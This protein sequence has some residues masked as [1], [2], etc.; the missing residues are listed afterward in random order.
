LC[1]LT[2]V[3]DAI[4]SD[5]DTLFTAEFW[6]ELHRLIGTKLK[7]ST[8]YH[9]ETDGATERA[10]RTVTQM[11]RVCVSKDQSDWVE[12]EFA[13][14]SA[15]SDITGHSPFFLNTGRVMKAM[16]FDV[17]EARFKG[18]H[19]FVDRVRDA[20]T[21]AHD[22]ILTHRVKQTIQANKRRRPASFKVGDL[23]YLSTEN[24]SIPKGKARKLIPKYIGPMMITKEVTP[25]TSYKLELP[26]ELQKRNL[27]DTFHAKLLRIHSPNDDRRFPGRS[28]HQITG[29]GADAK[30]WLV[31]KIEDHVGS[32]TS[33]TCKVRWKEHAWMDYPSVRH[34]TALDD[35]L[36]LKGSDLIGKL[37]S[38][39]TKLLE[40]EI[41]VDTLRIITSENKLPTYQCCCTVFTALE[42]N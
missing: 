19:D 11:L 1:Q 30:E 20:L 32:G 38:G 40:G 26:D 13:I 5:R 25:N 22:A 37:R 16:I 41:E 18:V 34:L 42:C 33:A 29:I 31:D 21:Q 28:F 6:R 2:I 14:N 4:V 23:V 3:P 9:P 8:A 24:I 17:S 15:K 7:M 10:N 36:I 12:I 39:R 35:Y 27:V